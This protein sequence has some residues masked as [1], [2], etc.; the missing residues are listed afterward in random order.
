LSVE[1]LQTNPITRVI[2]NGVEYTYDTNNKVFKRYDDKSKMWVT[3]RF[4]NNDIDNNY[5]LQL[6]AAK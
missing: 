5:I 1:L 2:I 4:N 3:V 6:L